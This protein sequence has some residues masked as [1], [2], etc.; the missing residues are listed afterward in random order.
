MKTLKKI[1]FIVALLMFCAF[2]NSSLSI[3]GNGDKLIG[4]WLNQEGTSH[5]RIGKIESGQLAGKFFGKI[6]W[7]KET[8][9]NGKPRTDKNNPDKTLQSAPLLGAMILRNFVYDEE[10]KVWEDGTVYDPKN[11]KTYSGNIHIN[12]DFSKLALRGYVGISLLGRTA[13]WTRVK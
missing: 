4:D 10:N 1:T 6:V 12:A 9:E 2:S 13:V 7:L 8:E 3:E 5:I 11:G